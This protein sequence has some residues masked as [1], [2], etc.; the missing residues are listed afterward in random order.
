MAV[1]RVDERPWSCCLAPSVQFLA[2]KTSWSRV[3]HPLIV[4]T[5]VEEG[6]HPVRT[7]RKLWI[8][9]NLGRKTPSRIIVQPWNG[10]KCFWHQF[11]RWC[12][13]FWVIEINKDAW[14]CEWQW[15]SPSCSNSNKRTCNSFWIICQYCERNFTFGISIPS[16]EDYGSTGTVFRVISNIA[17][18]VYQILLGGHPRKRSWVL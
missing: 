15:D 3:Q 4:K 9:L 18:L 1:A 8:L 5:F 2:Q 14:Q 12:T 10:F 16:L 7:K 6:E 17:L 13:T 11:T